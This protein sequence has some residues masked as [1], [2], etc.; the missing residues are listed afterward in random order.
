[1]SHQTHQIVPFQ[2]E[3][4][5][6]AKFPAHPAENSSARANNSRAGR[7]QLYAQP[8]DI[9]DSIETDYVDAREEDAISQ[10]SSEMYSSDNAMESDSDEEEE[11]E[12]T[13]EAV[14]VGPVIVN[15]RP[16]HGG[17]RPLPSQQS[18]ESA[19]IAEIIGQLSPH[20]GLGSSVSAFD[21]DFDD[22]CRGCRRH[23]PGRAR[24]R[25]PAV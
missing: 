20:L 2:A 1:M 8:H 12:E 3:D 17:L 5:A 11:K 23:Y 18:Q 22:R 7:A 4:D 13:I 19:L 9:Q 21:S 6:A 24:T 14:G 10:D 25:R 15:G 16:I